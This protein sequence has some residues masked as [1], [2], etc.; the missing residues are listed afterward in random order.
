M[1]IRRLQRERKT[2]PLRTRYGPTATLVPVNAEAPPST[3][4]EQSPRI[5]RLSFVPCRGAVG[6]STF[7]SIPRS[8]PKT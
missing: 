3:S 2:E 7:P 6:I 8:L 4:G 1:P 5:L